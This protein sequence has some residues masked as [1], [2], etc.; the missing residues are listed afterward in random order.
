MRKL[1]SILLVDDDEGTNYLHKLII[2]KHQ[3]SEIIW[4][5]RDGLEAL[6]LI[7]KNNKIDGLPDVIFLDLKMPIMSGFQFLEHYTKLDQPTEKAP[8]III[9]SSQRSDDYTRVLSYKEVIGFIEKPIQ[10]NK[11]IEFWEKHFS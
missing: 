11:L 4:E 2:E 3:L 7:T 6:E 5:A 9:S 1:K 10:Q 8:V